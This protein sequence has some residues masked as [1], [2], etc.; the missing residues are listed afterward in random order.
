MVR[1]KSLRLLLRF[2][3]PDGTITRLWDRAGTFVSPDHTVWTEAGLIAGSLAAIERA[4]NGDTAGLAITFG[5]AS[6][7][8]HDIAFANCRSG[9]FEGTKVR[10]LIQAFGDEEQPLGT[11]KAVYLACLDKLDFSETADGQ[12]T[13][14]MTSLFTLRRRA[15]LAALEHGAPADRA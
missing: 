13:A 1:A 5:G 9:G 8:R 10:I 6:R 7:E 14:T 15:Q 12:V 11:P 2:D 3:W 4:I